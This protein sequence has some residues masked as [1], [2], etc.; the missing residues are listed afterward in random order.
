M[1]KC[2]AAKGTAPALRG[3][4]EWEVARGCGVEGAINTKGSPALLLLSH[5]KA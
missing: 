5:V 2:P 1:G 4:C 3:T